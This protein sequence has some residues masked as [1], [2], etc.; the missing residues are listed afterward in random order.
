ETAFAR[1]SKRVVKNQ[2]TACQRIR[3]ALLRQ[4]SSWA[5]PSPGDQ[6]HGIE[7]CHMTHSSTRYLF[8]LALVICGLAPARGAEVPKRLVPVAGKPSHPPRMH[9][10]NAGVQLLAKCLKDVP[11]VKTEVVVN[12]WPADE[13]IFEN[14]D[15]I[16]FYMDGGAGHELVKEDGRRLKLAEGWVKHGIGIG[17]MHYG[18]GVRTAH[19]R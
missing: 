4:L 15:A 3:L 19:S 16:V 17:C 8:A 12:G 18:V 11:R 2:L 9:E 7:D 1:R 5:A 6:F 13:A 14:A 10:F